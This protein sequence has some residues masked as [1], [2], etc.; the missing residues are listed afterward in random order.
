VFTAPGDYVF[1]LGASDTEFTV[2]D[3]VSL[4][5]PSMNL[6]PAV[7][8]G[9]SQIIVLDEPPL[10]FN[11]LTNTG[12]D[13]P[14]VHGEIFG[15]D[16]V[17]GTEW[18]Q[19][20]QSPAP[21]AGDHYFYAGN[22]P[23]GELRQ[24]VD[25]SELRDRIDAGGQVF[26]FVGYVHS[27]ATGTP[28][29]AR[30]V[31]EY[32]DRANADV[33]DAFDSGPI[34]SQDAWHLVTDSRMAPAGTGFI[35]VRLISKRETGASN[36]GYFDSL[37]LY[38]PSGTEV[39]LDGLV[40]DD[41]LPAGAAVASTWSLVSG[42]DAVA[43]A[44]PSSPVTK[45]TLDVEGEYVLRLSATDTELTNH[46]DVTITLAPR[47]RAPVVDAGPDQ[48]LASTG[49]VALLQ[50][51]A[52]DDGLPAD[53]MLTMAWT[54]ASGP[55][56]VVFSSAAAFDTEATFSASGVYVLR[57]TA[58]DGELSG[59]DELTVT[60]DGPNQPPVVDAGPDETL[61][62]MSTTLQGS[63]ADDGLPVG[64]SLLVT[65]TQLSGPGTAL[66]AN[67]FSA[68]TGVSFDA[69][70]A[71]RLQLQA[72]D[73]LATAADEVVID[74]APA[75]A[76]SDLTVG[77]IDVSGATFDAQT[78][79]LGG[80]VTVEVVNVGLGDAVG[81]FDIA[82]F[83]DRNLNGNFEPASD[84][85][86]GTATHEGGLAA[87]GTADHTVAVAGVLEFF[88][89]PVHVFVDHANA[90]AESREDNNVGNT[91]PACNFVPPVFGPL[92]PVEGWTWD[93]STVQPNR[94]DVIST[95]LVI[96]LDL[97]GTPEVVFTS[98]AG[99]AAIIRV[100][101]G[102]DGTELFAVDAAGL[103]PNATSPLAA[104]DIDRDGFPELIAVTPNQRQLMALEHDGTLKWLSGT[105]ED[106]GHGGAAIADLDGDGLPEI[107]I[108][109]QVLN[110]DGSLRWT[111]AGSRSP[112]YGQVSL[113]ADLDRDG[114]PEIVA[115]NTAY[116]ATA[117]IFW[118]NEGVPAGFNAVGNFDA[119]P[120]PEVVV[121]ASGEVWL[122]EH[123]G[124]VKWGPAAHPGGGFG[125][126]PTV[127]DFDG[128][129]S[130]ETGVAGSSAYAVFDADGTLLWESRIQDGSSSRTGSSVFDFEGDGAA[131][132]VYA[133]EE[134]LR[135]YRGTDG[136]LL[137]EERIGSGHAA[138]MESAHLPHHQHQRRRHG[139]RARG[140][141][142]G[143]LQ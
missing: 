74:V 130:A 19:R 53:S 49:D 12:N 62:A 54:V 103:E 88:A 50:G 120:F 96:D 80:S 100:V 57:L 32:R 138:D 64:S 119:D 126:P 134:F 43:F 56:N 65:W 143:G 133:D 70:G 59:F 75:V 116:R 71:Y 86:L 48:V 128:D 85:L 122:L 139:T 9:P 40:L 30:I 41:D 125:G 84:N 140:E 135:V 25:V 16:E 21:H 105:I 97:N 87:G 137:F 111:G 109:R 1:E 28:D 69:L 78:L 142:L 121:V 47:N 118:Q 13:L 123:S 92:T 4:S 58:D 2:S 113:V 36:D 14:L 60:V 94:I 89:N 83:E 63:T 112:A 29:T 124:E 33:L 34:G 6:A 66:F 68:T 37:Q 136:G 67:R 106:T 117:S 91:E 17:Q 45:V 8:A 115:G 77:A 44:N 38:A 107:V 131:E 114:S 108:G 132:V 82:V 79:A 10:G 35:R 72:S 127:A 93:S 3:S 42:P 51:F 20:S 22:G 55:G 99:N 26:R 61:D 101:S 18:T 11:L 46:D 102:I 31:V 24:D 23:L 73:S 15:W 76:P 27:F 39:D 81:S 110:N 104:G 95:P 129:G 5:V 52:V 141:Q 90:I 7:D 98:R